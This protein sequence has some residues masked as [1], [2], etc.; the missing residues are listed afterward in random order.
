MRDLQV[1][2]QKALTAKGK[3]LGI[4]GCALVFRLLIRLVRISITSVSGNFGGGDGRLARAD[5]IAPPDDTVSML[6]KIL[7]GRQFILKDQQQ[8]LSQML[9]L[10]FTVFLAF[11]Q[12]NSFLQILSRI[13]KKITPNLEAV[14]LR[15]PRNKHII[16]TEKKS[17]NSM[18]GDEFILYPIS[19]AMGCYLLS[20][21]ALMH[22]NLPFRYRVA[23]TSIFRYVPPLIVSRAAAN[24]SFAISASLSAVTFLLGH[25]IEIQYLQKA[26]GYVNEHSLV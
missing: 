11:S 8:V 17:K 14:C 4:L 2:S 23:S 12:I 25:V 6:T 22:L 13:K 9:S 15:S 7:L 10:I 24:I 21:V 1:L 19:L 18:V 16:P 26:K 3:L 20:C 5:G